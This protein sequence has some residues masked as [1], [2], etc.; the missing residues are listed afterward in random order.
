[1]KG[2]IT[3]SS[4]RMILACHHDAV[5]LIVVDCGVKVNVLVH[6]LQVL[7]GFRQRHESVIFWRTTFF[8]FLR[9]CLILVSMWFLLRPVTTFHD[10]DD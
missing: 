7:R 4:L 5:L 3:S 2:K 10:F 1:M 8:F 6:D 9:P